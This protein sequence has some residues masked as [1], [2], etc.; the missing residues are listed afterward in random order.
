MAIRIYERVLEAVR[1]DR[2]VR[3]AVEREGDLLFVQGQPYDLASYR[4]VWIA[5][6]GKASVAM[7]QALS[8]VLGERL[9]GGVVVTKHA[10]RIE[11]IEV[12]EAAHPVPDETS[13]KAGERLLE[14]AREVREDDLVLFVLSGGASALVEAPVEGI[15]LAELQETNR[16]LLASGADITLMNAVRSRISRIKAGGLARAF[17]PATVVALVLS[18]VIGNALPT[19][20]SGPLVAAV[21]KELPYELLDALPSPVRAEVLA[22]ELFPPKTPK[23]D[24]YVIG[25]VSVAVHAA[26]DAARF[27]GVVPLPYGDPMQGEARDMA[28]KIVAL[29][30]RQIKARPGEEFCLIFGGETTVTLR[31]S[32]RGGR[33]QEMALAV[34]P[35]I[36]RLPGTSFLA[37]GTDGTD[38]PTDA[39][40]GLVD[41]LSLERAKDA[42][43]D[44]RRALVNNDSYRFLTASGGLVKTG[45]TGSNVND[46]CLVV[47]I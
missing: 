10:E 6:A 26:A 12:I 40:G 35:R 38:G 9:A 3:A 36:A 19:I 4:R 15:S 11:G 42:K 47:R 17:V 37:A 34:A 33:C 23:V 31:G 7:A 20:G 1:A 8:E 14:L 29:A 39:A 21:G 32:G 43:V 27:F 41:P 25:S 44:H 5:G 45:P 24:H 30:G 2:L 18:D 13:L 46:L 28:R 22:G 16:V